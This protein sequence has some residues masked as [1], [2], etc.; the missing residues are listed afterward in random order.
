MAVRVGKAERRSDLPCG[1]R[2]RS[3]TSNT[4]ALYDCPLLCRILVFALPPVAA[5]ATVRNAVFHGN[6]SERIFKTHLQ[7][8]GLVAPLS[9]PLVNVC[10]RRYGNPRGR[11]ERGAKVGRCK[12]YRETTLFCR[13]QATFPKDKWSRERCLRAALRR[14]AVD[15][16]KK[17][18]HKKSPEGSLQSP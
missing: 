16:M 10:H 1:G 12:S 11:P 8:Q 3:E 5:R 13:R 2:F 4:F 9:P 17:A 15:S 7:S 18:K 14:N 6:L